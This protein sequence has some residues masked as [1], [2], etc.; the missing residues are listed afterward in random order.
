[1]SHRRHHQ[2]DLMDVDHQTDIRLR[3]TAVDKSDPMW[4][5]SVADSIHRSTHR[6]DQAPIR[7][8]NN[9]EADPKGQDD[10]MTAA[11]AAR[12]MMH[13]TDSSNDWAVLATGSSDSLAS[14]RAHNSS[15]VHSCLYDSSG[16]L[17]LRRVCGVPMSL[18]SSR[19]PRHSCANG[20]STDRCTNVAGMS[21]EAST[22]RS[23]SPD[24]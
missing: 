3:L 14:R 19:V 20:G 4:T 24:H 2:L 10:S 12:A 8:S 6:L 17:R 18:D 1:M 15:S 7:D 11:V 13:S 23:K 22:D 9:S 16:H 21:S 5:S